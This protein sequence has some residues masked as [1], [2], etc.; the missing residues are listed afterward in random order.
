MREHEKADTKRICEDPAIRLMVYQLAHLF[1]GVAGSQYD[2]V[3]YINDDAACRE[4]LAELG[5]KPFGAS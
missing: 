1:F 4:R 5:L 2:L 3:H